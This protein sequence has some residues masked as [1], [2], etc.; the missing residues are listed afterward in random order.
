M[1]VTQS[2]RST[3]AKW[4]MRVNLGCGLVSGFALLLMMVVGAVDVAGTNLDVLGLT[5]APV[6]AAFE[7]MATMMVVNVFLAMSLGQSRRAHIRVEVLVNLLP[8]G[9]QRTADVVQHLFS[10][11]LFALIA[12]FGWSGAL[13]SL[14][15]GEYEPGIIN[16][17][18]WPA[19]LVLAFGATLMAVQCL[20]DL[21]GVFRPRLRANE[22]AHPAPPIS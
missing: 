22:D 19:R 15:V 6:P 16:Y 11:V 9:G 18:V 21:L 7:F 17:P 10:M 14:S 13:H 20:F 12:W 5:S 3:A 8:R 2:E 1:E 4:L